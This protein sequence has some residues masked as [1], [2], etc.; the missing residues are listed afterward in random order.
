M[1]NNATP[2][3]APAEIPLPK[4]DDREIGT[5][6]ASI[7]RAYLALGVD[8]LEPDSMDPAYIGEAVEKA[9]AALRAQVERLEDEKAEWIGTAEME[10]ESRRRITNDRDRLA[11]ELA[12]MAKE[13]DRIRSE[14]D[15]Y[16]TDARK[17]EAHLQSCISYEIDKRQQQVR[18]LTTL[19]HN[20]L[21][22]EREA[23][24]RVRNLASED[25]MKLQ[26]DRDAARAELAAI[27]AGTATDEALQFAL[28]CI[29]GRIGLTECSLSAWSKSDRPEAKEQVLAIEREAEKQRA[30]RAALQAVVGSGWIKCS[31]QAPAE[32][33]DVDAI[34]W[35]G[36]RKMAH[37]RNG[38][39][40][41]YGQMG[42]KAANVA[43]KFWRPLPPPPGEGE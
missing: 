2:P 10:Q 4:Y 28:Q 22:A 39:W 27:K 34:W 35:G 5:Y 8:P 32:C 11:A 20:E 6:L 21:A 16:F 15:T 42:I 31:D 19:H 3:A 12:A 14:Y 29:D 41:Y 23:T 9:I 43:P 1:N 40:W 36:D 17:R 37:V 33:V 7:D 13:R 26:A 38:A 25:A 30:M 18:E 24:A